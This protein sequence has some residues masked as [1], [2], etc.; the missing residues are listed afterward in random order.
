ML[1]S[2]PSPRKTQ[3]VKS[4][5]CWH[6]SNM[7]ISLLTTLGVTLQL[8]LATAQTKVTVNAGTT[9]QVIDGFGFSEAFG[10]GGGVENAPAAQQ[11]QALNYMFS[12]TE[13]AGMTILR[14]R[15]A[16]DPNGSIEPNSPGSPSAAPTYKAIGDDS[17]QVRVIYSPIVF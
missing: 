15:I 5:N 17:S 13:G 10:F 14:N 7:H 1:I 4:N 11:T 6:S 12:T 16:A 3:S 2:S 8:G 9:Y